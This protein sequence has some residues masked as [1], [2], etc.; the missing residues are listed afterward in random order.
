GQRVGPPAR[1]APT[2]GEPERRPNAAGE[3]RFVGNHPRG[4]EFGVD[5]KVVVGA[6]PAVVIPPQ[7]ARQEQ[8]VP[9]PDLLLHI[10]TE[11]LV[12][13]VEI[14][15]LKS[16]PDTATTHAVDAADGKVYARAGD[17]R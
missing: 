16:L 3:K 15:A 14:R 11:R 2:N 12:F 5:H 7:R 9:Q 6:E 17:L 10:D 13:E 1:L 8:S 4:A